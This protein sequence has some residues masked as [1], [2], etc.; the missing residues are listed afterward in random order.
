MTPDSFNVPP[1]LGDEVVSLRNWRVPDAAVLIAAYADPTI[2][3]NIESEHD[4]TIRT[5]D[6][7]MRFVSGARQRRASEEGLPLAICAN[8]SVVGG[9]DLDRVDE[10]RGDEWEVGV[11]LIAS[12]RGRGYAFRALTVGIGWLKTS[13]GARRIWADA[14]AGNAPSLRLLERLGFVES[15]SAE[16]PPGM[17]SR[18]TSVVRRLELS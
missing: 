17:P 10:P 11:W 1:D 9:I 4:S 6:D 8:D 18:S 14:D 16:L 3:G 7:A 15:G 12:E 2:R 13:L 5:Y